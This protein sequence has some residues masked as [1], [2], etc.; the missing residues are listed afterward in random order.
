MELTPS[1]E[2]LIF[3]YPLLKLESLALVNLT[4]L[5][6]SKSLER[7]ADLLC[8]TKISH[9]KTLILKDVI[10]C[11]IHPQ[12]IVSLLLQNPNLNHVEIEHV[13]IIGPGG[14]Y[15]MK[16]PNLRSYTF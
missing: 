5:S 7:V 14:F 4:S 1:E 6:Q 2:T 3:S 11:H 8:M 10:L 13:D 15:P 16:F 9:L 12:D